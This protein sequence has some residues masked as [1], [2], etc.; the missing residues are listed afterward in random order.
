M[1]AL[2]LVFMAS[3]YKAVSFAYTALKAANSPLA[4]SMCPGTFF[5]PVLHGSGIAAVKIC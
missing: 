5:S 3:W 4:L 1:L 2:P